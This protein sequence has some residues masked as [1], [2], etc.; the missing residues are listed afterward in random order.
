MRA[1]PPG[2]AGMNAPGE[3]GLRFLPGPLPTTEHLPITLPT[4]GPEG[5]MRTMMN[6]PLGKCEGQV[7]QPSGYH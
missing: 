7:C 2:I 4:L 6:F 5:D 1:P 3:M